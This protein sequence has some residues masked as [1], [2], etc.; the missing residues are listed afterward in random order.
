[1]DC[2]DKKIYLTEHEADVTQLPSEFPWG[3]AAEYCI[4]LYDRM[5][6]TRDSIAELQCSEV[7][8][9]TRAVSSKINDCETMRRI[10]HEIIKQSEGKFA[11]TLAKDFQKYLKKTTW[12]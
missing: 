5:M 2:T 12:N 11:D 4:R 3:Q 9:Y 7:P 8:A 1:M 6:N 10:W